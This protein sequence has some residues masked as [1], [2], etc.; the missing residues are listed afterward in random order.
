MAGNTNQEILGANP[1]V[2]KLPSFLNGQ[3][4]LTEMDAAGT[5]RKRDVESIVD[6]NAR[7]T[8]IACRRSCGTLQG[9]ARQ[10]GAI[11]A[12]KIFFANLY[13]VDAHG[14]RFFN[15]VQEGLARVQLIG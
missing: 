1:R 5:L 9:C 8:L 14:C 6:E 2:R 11:L 15:H 3:T 7:R 12:R 13:P 4:V 10:C